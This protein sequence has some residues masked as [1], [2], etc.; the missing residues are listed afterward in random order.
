M[1]AL[2]T[3]LYA[4]LRRILLYI[5]SPRRYERL[6]SLYIALP[7]KVMEV[8]SNALSSRFINTTVL[9]LVGTRSNSIVLTTNIGMIVQ[10]VHLSI[11]YSFRY[12][13][14]GT[15]YILIM[16][17]SYKSGNDP[18]FKILNTTKY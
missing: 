2:F 15:K 12:I 17:I 11:Q 1:R 6:I 3:G 5:F 14:A 7:I 13:V 9:V 16:Y 8:R 4:I 18:I 10:N